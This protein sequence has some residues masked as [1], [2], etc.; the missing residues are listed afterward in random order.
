MLKYIKRDLEQPILEA[1]KANYV[2][3]ILGARQVGKTTLMGKLRDLLTRETFAREHSF[4]FNLDDVLLRQQVSTDF[5]FILNQIEQQLGLPIDEAENQILVFIDEAQKVPDV[6]EL[7]KMMHDEHKDKV[8]IILSGSS[9]LQIQKKSAESLAGRILHF[10]LFPL[11]V[12]EI[13]QERFDFTPQTQLF[14]Q[15]LSAELDFSKLQKQQTEIIGGWERRRE[16]SLLLDRL[17]LDGSLPAVW[18]DPSQ[19]ELVYK[20]LT[21]TYLEK[22][23]RA[24][25]KVGSL[26]DFTQLL[27]LLS[28]EVGAV[29]NQHNLSQSAGIAVNTLKKYRSILAATFV[30]NRLDPLVAPRRRMVKSPK[31]YFFDVGVANFLAGREKLEHLQATG[32]KGALFE[33]LL[34]KSLESYSQNSLRRPQLTFWRDYQDHEIDLVV[35]SGNKKLPV[36]MTPSDRLSS[37]KKRNFKHFFED[38][39]DETEQGLVIYTGV[40][41][42]VR[43]EEKPV[44]LVPWWLW[45]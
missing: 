32:V 31:M 16:F 6:F 1:L 23:I 33:N 28:F 44:F 39:G 10:Y 29:L 27:R 7:V 43:I 22:D 37:N 9:S 40:L 34:L 25:A 21:E 15:L 38:F 4:F 3:A 19:K 36:E 18:Q 45:W 41:D 26:E 13:L 12:S 17:L 14:P 24:L 35:S 2:V 42:R 5:Y 30:T 20:S 8:K 11:S